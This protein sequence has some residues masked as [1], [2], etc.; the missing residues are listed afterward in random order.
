MRRTFLTTGIGAGIFVFA[1]G[2]VFGQA[3]EGNLAFAVASVRPSGPQSVRGSN[4]GPGTRDPERFT[5]SGAVLRDLL[6]N[7]YLKIGVD[8]YREQI[9]GPGWIDT[10]KYDIAVK[11]PPGT[12]KE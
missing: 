2:V 7:A 3:A 11:I 8:D 9:S 1:C 4:G 12:T 5:F 10:E 6:F